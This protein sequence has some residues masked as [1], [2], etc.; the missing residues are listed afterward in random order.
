MV[1]TNVGNG[2]SVKLRVN[3]RGPTQAD[4]IGDVSDAAARRLGFVHAGLTE[5]KLEVA[6]TAPK[7]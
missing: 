3:D 7:Q 6:G 1:V 4:R 5:A 2:K